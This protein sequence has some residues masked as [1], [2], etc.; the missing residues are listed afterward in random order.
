MSIATGAVMIR[1]LFALAGLALLSGCATTTYYHSD[2]SGADYY[3]GNDSGYY[4]RDTTYVSSARYVMVGDCVYYGWYSSPGCFAMGWDWYNPWPY[5]NAWRGWGYPWPGY[6]GNRWNVS[7]W[8]GFGSFG[9]WGYPGYSNPWFDPYWPWWA[10]YQAPQQRHHLRD[11][12]DLRRARALQASWRGYGAVPTGAGLRAAGLMAPS[13]ASRSHAVRRQQAA[14]RRA[15]RNANRPVRATRPAHGNRTLRLPRGRPDATVGI[16]IDLPTSRDRVPVF[17]HQ[18]RAPRRPVQRQPA[19]HDTSTVTRRIPA[20]PVLRRPEP[21]ARPIQ[22]IPIQRSAPHRATPRPA[23]RPTPS[24]A[25]RIHHSSPSPAPQSA[26]PTPQPRIS[27]PTRSPRAAPRGR[28]E[29]R[30]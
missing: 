24:P 15:N 6:Y 20:T 7:L 11:R 18:P 12:R 21:R 23:P 19:R 4:D 13:S 9:L 2:P 17:R 26:P 22:R 5:H 8:L 30:R 27:A 1:W 28:P 16:P 3:Y 10:A 25:P 14:A 29:R